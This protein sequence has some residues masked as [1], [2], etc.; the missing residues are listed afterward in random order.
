MVGFEEISG[1]T[2][3]NNI[4]D[5]FCYEDNRANAPINVGDEFC[6]EDSRANAPK[7]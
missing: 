1:L 5:E 2:P 6:Y 4:G 3:L 7:F